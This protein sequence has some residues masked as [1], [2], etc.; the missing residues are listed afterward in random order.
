[1]TGEGPKERARA[2][3]KIT[4]GKTEWFIGF[5]RRNSRPLLESGVK[6]VVV[7]DPRKKTVTVYRSQSD[8]TI[9]SD[10]AVLDGGDVV[11]GWQLPIQDLFT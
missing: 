7:V 5:D 4:P 9:L 3:E 8:I 2:V 1:V 10:D 11:P 6:I